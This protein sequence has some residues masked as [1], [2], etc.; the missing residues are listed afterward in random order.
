VGAR[1]RHAHGPDLLGLDIWVAVVELVHLSVR[2]KIKYELYGHAGVAE[3]HR[4][5]HSFVVLPKGFAQLH[6]LYSTTG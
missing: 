2:K 3:A 5:A 6:D 1:A 4:A